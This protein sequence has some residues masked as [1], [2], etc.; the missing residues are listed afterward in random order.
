MGQQSKIIVYGFE[1]RV[2]ALRVTGLSHEEI[3]AI[4]TRE[5]KS[6][7]NIEDTVSRGAV[8][9]FLAKEMEARG[10]IIS[11]IKADYVKESAVTDLKVLEEMKAELYAIWQGKLQAVILPDSKTY[12]YVLRD[13]ENARRELAKVIELG[14]RFMGVDGSQVPGEGSDPVDLSKYRKPEPIANKSAGGSS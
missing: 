11:E 3:A 9:R 6:E 4:V 10:Q 1:S 2:L 13:R 5:L 14:W 8:T 12:Y 7:K